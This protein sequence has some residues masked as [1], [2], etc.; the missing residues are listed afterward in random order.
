MSEL[1]HVGASGQ[2]VIPTEV[3]YS[4]MGRALGGT[5]GDILNKKR[6]VKG[7]VWGGVGGGG[8]NICSVF[9]DLSRVRHFTNALFDNPHN[10]FIR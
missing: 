6:G 8:D 7:G 1:L 10:Y 3:S 4:F 9:K 2:M 5:W